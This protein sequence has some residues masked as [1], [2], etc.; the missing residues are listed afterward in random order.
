M[1][2]RPERLEDPSAA[3]PDPLASLPEG[4]VAIVLGATGGV[5][6]ALVAALREHPKFAHVIAAS[7][8][9]AHRFDLA[10]ENS[11]AALAGEAAT[12]GEIRLA[13]DATGLLWNDRITPEKSLREIDPAALAESYAVNAIGPALL[14]KHF[15]PHLPRR[16]RSVFATL[17]ARVGSIGDNRLGGWY[18]YRAAKAA[19]NQ[20]VRSAA[21]ELRRT[22]PEAI[23]VALHPGTVDTGLSQPFARTGL[24]VHTPEAAAGHLLRV[25]GGL[26]REDSGGFRDW[27]GEVIP[28]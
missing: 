18:G 25:I 9:E 4:G 12:L 2:E 15:A 26:S 14:I 19:L 24:K 13:I 10:D 22:R 16:G 20:I 5:G 6:G 1:Q 27:Q 8:R 7:R 28:W 23:C 17:S 11:I 3:T 21:V